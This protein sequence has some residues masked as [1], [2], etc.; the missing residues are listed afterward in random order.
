MKSLRI[1]LACSNQTQLVPASP[2]YDLSS[3][4]SNSFSGSSVITLLA[5]LPIDSSM[6]I[7]SDLADSQQPIN[8]SSQ[9]LQSPNVYP[10]SSMDLSNELITNERV[11]GLQEKWRSEL[12]SGLHP[13]TFSTPSIK[14]RFSFTDSH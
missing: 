8:I 13:T 1:L 4:A 2:I 11:G 3:Q 7:N 10:S 6:N 12:L 9:I 14:H 5:S